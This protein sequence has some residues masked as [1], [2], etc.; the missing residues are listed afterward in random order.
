MTAQPQEQ[1]RRQRAAPIPGKRPAPAPVSPFRQ[2]G[3]LKTTPQSV[4]L[5]PGWRASLEPPVNSEG[6]LGETFTMDSQKFLVWLSDYFADDVVTLRLTVR[7]M[8][9]ASPGGQI[10][11]TQQKLAELLTEGARRT[12]AQEASKGADEGVP[13]GTGRK[14]LQSQVNR[15]LKLLSKLGIIVKVKAGLYQFQP[16]LSLRGGSV[17]V[18]P[19]PGTR[20]YGKLKVDQLSLLDVIEADEALPEEFKYL[21]Q[22]PDPANKPLRED[23]A[24]QKAREERKG[25]S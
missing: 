13:G 4:E 17:P 23:K 16:R 10:R 14:I 20:A 15:S 11:V 5:P 24:R 8:G 3:A 21:R 7:M 18:E 2:P 25:T 6:F 9:M 1:P 22:L 19:K 12:A